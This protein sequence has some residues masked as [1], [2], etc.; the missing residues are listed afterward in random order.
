[1]TPKKRIPRRPMRTAKNKKKQKSKNVMTVLLGIL[2]TGLVTVVIISVY[3]LIF[4]I[5]FVRGENKINLEQY[6]ENQDQTTIV[7]AYDHNNE[8]TELARLLGEQNRVW[9]AYCEDPEESVIPENLAKAY[10]ALEDKRFYKHDGV[11]WSRTL[12]SA[13]S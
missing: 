2:L 5:S 4:S 3:L 11:D 6:K 7:Y 1:M 12:V 9:V 13:V 8:E 10:V